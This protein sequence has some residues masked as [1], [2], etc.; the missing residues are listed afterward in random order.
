[1]LLSVV[2][3]INNSYIRKLKIDED[4]QVIINSFEI[5]RASILGE[6]RFGN[7]LLKQ[8]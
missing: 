7:K 2:S 6:Y 4:N 3:L 5:A 8:I 1:M